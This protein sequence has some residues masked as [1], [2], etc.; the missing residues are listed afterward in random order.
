MYVKKGG[1][2]PH[3]SKFLVFNHAAKRVEGFVRILQNDRYQIDCMGQH[4][5][6]NALFACGRDGFWTD[7]HLPH[8][9]CD[10]WV[11][12]NDRKL[13]TSQ[14]AVLV[15]HHKCTHGM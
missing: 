4:S 10:Y 13:I 15:K 7:G 2:K 11:T 3:R 9:T 1:K 5:L 8:D 14:I 6:E 12:E